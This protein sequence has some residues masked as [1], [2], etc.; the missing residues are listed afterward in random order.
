MQDENKNT[1]AKAVEPSY[2]DIFFHL[3]IEFGTAK[4]RR[5]KLTAL[6]N[7]VRFSS[8][9]TKIRLILFVTICTE[10]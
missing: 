1:K 3:W 2:L 7:S 5:L 6:L 10:Q 4:A 9:K 8:I